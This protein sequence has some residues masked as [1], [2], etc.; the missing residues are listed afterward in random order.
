M[1]DKQGSLVARCH[2]NIARITGDE[3]DLSWIRFG[4]FVEKETNI[5][6]RFPAREALKSPRSHARVIKEDSSKTQKN[7]EGLTVSEHR[8][9]AGTISLSTDERKREDKTDYGN[10]EKSAIYPVLNKCD[11]SRSLNN[12]L[13]IFAFDQ[14]KLPNNKVAL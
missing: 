5:T 13:E 2:R 11:V 1:R 7:G 4:T 8:V 9:H 6:P 14:S 10:H 3:H 12:D